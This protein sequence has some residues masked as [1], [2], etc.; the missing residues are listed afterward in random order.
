MYK[1]R[2][3]E[4]ALLCALCVS[5]GAALWADRAQSRLSSELIRLHILANSDSPEDQA[6][7]LRLRDAAL[8]L[9]T[10]LLEDCRSQAEAL[11]R[12]AAHRTE[13]ESLGDVTVRLGR[14]YYPARQY[15]GFSLPAGE[16]VSLRLVVGN[17]AGH[18]WWCVV[19]PP[20]CTEVLAED[21]ADS[22]FLMLDEQSADLIAGQDRE[23]DLRFRIVDWW[24][25]F[26]ELLKNATNAPA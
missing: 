4:T 1:L 21:E 14:E 24:G 20:L 9:L 16:Y 13:L 6:E 25:K 7:K 17:G 23:Y 10:P 2:L 22:A 15:E 18:N 8:E 3:W 5:L 19:F 26:R 11:D 12:I